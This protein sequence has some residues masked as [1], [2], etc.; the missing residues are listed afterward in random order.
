MTTILEISFNASSQSELYEIAEA[1][2]GKRLGQVPRSFRG[3]CIAS[4]KQSEWKDTSLAPGTKFY[5]DSV[6]W[7]NGAS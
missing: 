1:P 3:A 5:P 2:T 4:K 7:K 6:D